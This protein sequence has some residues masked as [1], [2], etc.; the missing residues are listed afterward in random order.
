MFTTLADGIQAELVDLATRFGQPSVHFA[1]LDS[2]KLFDPLNN[3]DRFGEVCMVVR[4]PNGQLITAKKVFYP[5]G[6]NR[7]LTGG[8]NHGER[9]LDALLRETQEETGLEVVVRRFLT[10]VAYHLPGQQAQP[11]F[12]TFAFLL[13][14]I[15]GELGC[16]DEHERLEY[17]REI[18]PDDLPE[19]AEF[20]A[21]LAH[22]YSQ[23]LGLGDDDWAEWG[24]FRAVIHRLVWEALH[25]SHQAP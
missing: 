15:G 9:V 2:A 7:L 8:I 6:C 4:R 14:E 3:L 19:R 11:V 10:A 23:D 1:E 24:K 17:F 21:H 20:L 25:F 22:S 18:A 5:A 12:Y 16:L 13:D